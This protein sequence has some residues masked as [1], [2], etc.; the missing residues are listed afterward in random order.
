MEAWYIV[1]RSTGLTIRARTRRAHLQAGRVAIYHCWTIS[2]HQPDGSRANV[3][4]ASQ[5]C[6]GYSLRPLLSESLFVKTSSIV[7][8]TIAKH[9]HVSRSIL[10]SSYCPVVFSLTRTC[11]VIVVWYYQTSTR[12]FCSG[13]IRR[14]APPTNH[15]FNTRATTRASSP[16]IRLSKRF[17]VAVSSLLQKR[18]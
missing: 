15:E 6:L 1:L 2:S 17:S 9:A 10:R 16:T 11:H 12:S 18:P 14:H 7:A 3:G 4:A 8:N 13:Q 5:R